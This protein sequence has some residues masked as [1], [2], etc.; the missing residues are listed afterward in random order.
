MWLIVL[1]ERNGRWWSHTFTPWI[2]FYYAKCEIWII[3]MNGIMVNTTGI[4]TYP[5]DHRIWSKTYDCF[6]YLWLN[7]IFISLYISD[8]YRFYVSSTPQNI[9]TNISSQEQLIVVVYLLS[10]SCDLQSCTS[11]C[12][13]LGRLSVNCT[14]KFLI[15]AIIVWCGGKCYY[16]SHGH[17]Y[18]Y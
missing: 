16:I 6:I 9:Y 7:I 13:L 18:R 5:L 4:L 14:S 1:P 8:K 12:W 11:A 17:G 15:G 2:I 3:K 10:V